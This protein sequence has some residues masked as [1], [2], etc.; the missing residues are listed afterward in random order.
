VSTLRQAREALG[1]RLRELRRDANLTG[2]ALADQLGWPQSK[3]SKIETGRQSP[4]ETD[5]AGWTRV[6]GSPEAAPDLIATLRTL[7]TMYAEWR[8][9]LHTGM[10]KRQQSI[11]EIEAEASSVRNFQTMFVPGLLQT[12]DYARSL[13]AESVEFHEVANDLDEAVPAR[14]RRQEVLY[15]ADK[16]FHFLVTEAV[17]RHRFCAADVLVD[18]LYRLVALSA[19]KNIRLGVIPFSSEF[20]FAPHHGFVI[21]DRR[22][23]L[24]ETIAAELSLTQHQEIAKYEKAFD[25]LVA[26]AVYGRDARHVITRTLDELAEECA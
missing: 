7:E 8:R 25:R 1:Q 23:V 26:S 3:V 9:Q 24:V 18:Q 16:R 2:Q 6:A 12:P 11:S 22:I 14:M 10:R 5:I 19:S 4:T 21:Y 13:M 15:R 17:L 20:R